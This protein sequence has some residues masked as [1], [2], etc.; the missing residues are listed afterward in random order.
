MPVKYLKLT[1]KRSLNFDCYVLKILTKA[2]TVCG[3]RSQDYGDAP[4]GGYLGID[5]L[6]APPAKEARGNDRVRPQ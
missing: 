5:V 2:L 3:L 1:R 6:T 4:N